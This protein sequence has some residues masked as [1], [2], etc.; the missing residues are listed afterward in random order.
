MILNR[1]TFFYFLLL[2]SVVNILC[3]N[4][5]LI[6]RKRRFTRAS[7][8]ATTTEVDETTAANKDQIVEI[9]KESSIVAAPETVGP[10]IQVDIA[11]KKSLRVRNCGERIGDD[12]PFIALLVHTNPYDSQSRKRT[13]SKG[14][15]ISEN[16]VITTV[17]SVYHSESFWT[18]T[19]VRLGDF[20][21]WNKYANRDKSYS[22]EIDIEEIY[23]HK[24]RD[25]A[26]IKLKESVNFTD[27]IR[28]ACL[29]QSDSYNFKELKSHLCKRSHHPKT[30]ADVSL[31]FA[32]PLS[33]FDCRKFF[34]RKRIAIS[35]YEF[36][37]WDETGDD[38][39]GD[40][41]TALFT[42]HNG[43]LFLVGLR[44]YAETD[45]EDIPDPSEYPGIYIKVGSY[46][47]WISA[48][49]NADS[50]KSSAL[51]EEQQRTE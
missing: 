24:K 39:A 32:A 16:F 30:P 20:V 41:A 44:S 9:T 38:C 4:E 21:T 2:L 13:L 42:I 8:L 35:Q 51:N 47:E 37:V 45:D 46:L 23:F 11:T 28:P 6:T 34:S 36:C 17:S 43:R 19:S 49:I 10:S 31:E 22:V 40:L 48:V 27:V 25:I 1:W 15:L 12:I 33:T 50:N 3:D 14:V 5:N 29:P 18:V 26:L 7:T